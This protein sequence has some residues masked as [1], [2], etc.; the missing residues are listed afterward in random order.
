MEG[1]FDCTMTNN[2][3]WSDCEIAHTL[4]F[5]VHQSGDGPKANI[6]YNRTYPM[7]LD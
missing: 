1:P 5:N 7:L 6:L 3:M 2:L 4:I